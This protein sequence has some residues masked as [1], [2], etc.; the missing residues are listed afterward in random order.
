MNKA[1]LSLTLGV[2]VAVPFVTFAQNLKT[3]QNPK[4]CKPNVIMIYADD[5]GMGM[6][7]C[8]GQKQFQT[9]NIDRLFHQGTQFSHTYGCMVSAASRASLLTGYFDVR[10][11]KIRVS[12]AHQLLFDKADDTE[13]THD[14]LDAK[15]K[16]VEDNIDKNDVNLPQG[17]WYLPQI[18][19]QAGYVTAQIGKLDYGWTATRDQLTRH[20]W[21]HYFGYLDHVGCHGYYPP[22]LFEDGKLVLVEGNTHKDCAKTQ[23]NET[24]AT[25]ANRWNMEG[26]VQYAQD[27]FDDKMAAFIAKNK[28][29]PFFLLHSTLLPHGPVMVTEVYDEIKNNPNL[30]QI[31]K[32]YA[33]M[34]IR[35]DKV[36][37]RLLEEVKKQGIA[38]RT[39]FIFTSDNG[40]EIY[41]A[42]AGRVKK[43]YG[44]YDDWNTKYYSDIHGDVFN[45]NGGLRGFKRQNSEGGPRVPMAIYWPGHIPSGVICNQFVTHIDLIPTFAEML[46]IGLNPQYPKDG[47][48]IFSTLI[49]GTPLS[50]N[51][52][53]VYS[54]YQGPAIVNNAGFKVR[55]NMTAKDYDMYYLLNDPQERRNIATQYPQRFEAMKNQLIKVCGGDITKGICHY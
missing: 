27:I 34:V 40:H 4:A 55:Y 3:V 10:K 33:S 6:L 48:S 19:Q 13:A 53:Y 52:Y 24:A 42:Q 46:G 38:D 20:G 50:A 9:P 35:L 47:V 14:A 5:M 8:M 29:N 15:C 54:S 16:A 11:E 21:D 1:R 17:D 28:D 2:G 43:P 12:R 7:S 26:K 49:D 32:E 45:G 41:Y 44:A 25:Y 39:I 22:Y 30:T 36:V 37:G 23:E 51:R 31:E 18:F